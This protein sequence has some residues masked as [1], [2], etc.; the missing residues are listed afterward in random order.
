MPDRPGRAGEVSVDGVRRS[1]AGERVLDGASFR[2]TEGSVTVAGSPPGSGLAGFVLAGTR[3]LN[4]RL[5]G[6]QKLA[7][8][9][10]V[11]GVPRE[12]LD[13]R[14]TAAPLAWT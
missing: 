7:F 13:S 3:M 1:F 6:R 4:L 10:R 14:L 8:F 2:Q 12:Q 5:S 11:A 9:A